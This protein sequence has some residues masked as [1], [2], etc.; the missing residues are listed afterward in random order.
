LKE[1]D[2]FLPRE[3]AERTAL[4]LLGGKLVLT[5][6]STNE[7][8]ESKKKNSDFDA[9]QTKIDSAEQCNVQ[10]KGNNSDPEKSTEKEHT[11]HMGSKTKFFIAIHTSYQPIHGSR[12][13]LSLI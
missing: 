10:P 9:I 2:K 7:D 3:L 5:G 4:N 1:K 12:H 13:P 6:R 11:V 8:P